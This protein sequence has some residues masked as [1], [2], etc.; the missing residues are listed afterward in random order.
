MDWNGLTEQIAL[1]LLATM[2]QQELALA[3]GFDSFSD[4]HQTQTLTQR[5]HSL[6]DGGTVRVGQHVM[7]K[8]FVYLEFVQG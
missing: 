1:K 3:F 2:A 5:D 7:H 6:G 8:G 4:H